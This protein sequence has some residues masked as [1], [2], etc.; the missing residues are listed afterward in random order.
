MSLKVTSFKLTLFQIGRVFKSYLTN[1]WA[2]FADFDAAGACRDRRRRR[3]EGAV[4]ASYATAPDLNWKYLIKETSFE[5]TYSLT[6]KIILS[7]SI[8]F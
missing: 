3:E 6:F 1:V 7:I 5:S 4:L 2:A 8:R